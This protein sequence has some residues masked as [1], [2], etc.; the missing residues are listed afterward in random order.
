[1]RSIQLLSRVRLLQLFAAPFLYS[2]IASACDCSPLR[3][4]GLSYA[5]ADFVGQIISKRLIEGPIES[6]KTSSN[7]QTQSHFVYQV[8]VLESYSKDIRTGQITEVLSGTGDADCSYFF[9]VGETHLIDATNLNGELWTSLCSRTGEIRD[10]IAEVREL[11]RRRSGSPQPDLS[12]VV[13]MD[14]SFD[15]RPPLAGV[16][17]SAIAKEGNQKLE[18]ITDQE[19]MYRFDHLSRGYWQLAVVGLPP[20]RRLS[21][22]GSSLAPFGT[23]IPPLWVDDENAE[24]SACRVD[25]DLTETGSILGKVRRPT[26]SKGSLS[27]VAFEVSQDGR[28]GPVARETYVEDDGTF[29]LRGLA[30]GS[31]IVAVE[32]KRWQHTHSGWIMH[33]PIFGSEAR[34]SIADGEQRTGLL[35]DAPNP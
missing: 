34:V 28:R 14:Q 27:V 26:A 21:N 20:H 1:M 31:Y 9:E 32:A 22:L 8:E 4:C 5:S 15:R 29:E 16:H 7:G 3:N 6:R 10:R 17:I 12:G 24:F 13:S 11:R 18:A 35:V 30:G 2:T 19:G 23:S 25:F 33:G